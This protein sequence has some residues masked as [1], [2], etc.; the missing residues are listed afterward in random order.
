MTKYIFGRIM[1]SIAGI[2]VVLIANFVIVRIIPG[3]PI[4]AIIGDFPAPPEYVAKLE[5]QLGLNEPIFVQLIKYFEQLFAGNLGFSFANG[6]EILPL[7]I[8]KAGFSLMLMIPGLVIASLLGVGLAAIG[9]RKPGTAV[10][11]AT[12]GVS[13]V[14]FSM[15]VFW[16]GQLLMLLFAVRLGWLPAQG[17]GSSPEEVGLWASILS[18]AEHLVMPVTCIA[19]FYMAVVARVS[20]SA[21]ASS[22]SQDYVRSA[23]YRGLSE[24]YVL[25]RHAVRSATGPIVTVIGYNFGSV[26]TGAVLT[27]TV[28]GWPGLGSLFVQSIDSRDYSVVQG[29]FLLTGVTVVVAN[30]IVD[31]LTAVLDPRVKAAALSKR[32]LQNVV[33]L[34]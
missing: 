24:R 28:F 2:F 11:S 29:V 21:I 15:P 5:A 13:L 6:Q 12:A 19:L 25:W 32:R 26:L 4:D 1:W 14:G 17:A 20:R 10:D 34:P 18:R 3:N 33:V 22:L 31:L 27:E 9:A 30:L 23:L 8:D 16:L 7:I